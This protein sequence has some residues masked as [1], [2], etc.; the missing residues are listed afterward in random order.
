MISLPD[1]ASPAPGE[2]NSDGRY[3]YV[4][5][6]RVRPDADEAFRREYGPHGGWVALFRR[7]P[8]YVSTQLYRDR[9]DPQRY[10]TIDTWESRA[11]HDRFRLQ[12]AD[13]FHALDCACGRLTVSEVR[14][15]E[16]EGV[17]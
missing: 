11:A 2:S 9:A 17:E 14:L 4:W 13:A 12:F 5:E 16:F 15:G 10:L 7:A 3:T 8:G 1:G 6:Y